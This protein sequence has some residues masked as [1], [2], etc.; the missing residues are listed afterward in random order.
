MSR[1]S[2]CKATQQPKS[3]YDNFAFFCQTCG[4]GGSYDIFAT[5][6][7]AKFRIV[8]RTVG[9]R[10]SGRLGTAVVCEISAEAIVSTRMKEWLHEQWRATVPEDL[11]GQIFHHAQW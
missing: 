6:A 8:L 2:T 11:S 7:Q 10:G 5:D 4:L 9:F 3:P 1:Q